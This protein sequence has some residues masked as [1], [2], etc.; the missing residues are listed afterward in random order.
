MGLASLLRL[1][2]FIK[3]N[4]LYGRQ[5]K[6]KCEK[7]SKQPVLH[8]SH[9]KLANYFIQTPSVRTKSTERRRKKFFEILARDRSQRRRKAFHFYASEI[10]TIHVPRNAIITKYR[11]QV[12]VPTPKWEPQHSK[13]IRKYIPKQNK[14]C[15]LILDWAYF[16]YMKAP[17]RSRFASERGASWKPTSALAFRRSQ[18]AVLLGHRPPQLI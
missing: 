3:W 17:L 7:D 18:Q 6:S 10:M 12:W 13:E 11:Y 8:D 5:D 15:D 14:V 9:S 1:L 4:C 16:T 2:D